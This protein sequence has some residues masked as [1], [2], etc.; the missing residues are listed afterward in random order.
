MLASELSLHFGRYLNTQF[1]SSA[2]NTNENFMPEKPK[3]SPLLIN[4][5]L[6]RQMFNTTNL[7]RP[8]HMGL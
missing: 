8:R 2:A 7:F 5:K 4:M 3:I 6:Q 1:N